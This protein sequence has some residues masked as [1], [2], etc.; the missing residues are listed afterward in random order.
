MVTGI[1]AGLSVWWLKLQKSCP[2]C[3][4]ALPRLRWPRSWRQL[5]WGGWTCENCGTEAD[6]RGNRIV[7]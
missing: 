6:A 4:K 3:K 7:A 5:L 2:S 1:T